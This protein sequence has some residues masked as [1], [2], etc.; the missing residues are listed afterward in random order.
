MKFCKI[1]FSRG[2]EW[3]TFNGKMCMESWKLFLFGQCVLVCDHSLRRFSLAAIHTLHHRS[4]FDIK[5]FL[6]N[7]F[8]RFCLV[9]QEIK[10][11][12]CKD[13]YSGTLIFS[14]IHFL[15]SWNCIIQKNARVLERELR[16]WLCLSFRMCSSWYW[17]K[18][19]ENY[20]GKVHRSNQSTLDVFLSSCNFPTAK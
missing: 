4:K 16:R 8:V 1:Y 3:S 9:I 13:A 19:I 7:F 17:W 2:F 14:G 6:K 5:K 20:T 11:F 18:N 12:W 15:V 10:C